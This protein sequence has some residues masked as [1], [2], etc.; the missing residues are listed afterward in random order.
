MTI[1]AGTR[2]IIRN[3]RKKMK[4]R[5]EKTSEGN[6]SFLQVDAFTDVE[7]SFGTKSSH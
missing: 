2:L 7:S 5:I 4:S 3:K 1:H 6:F